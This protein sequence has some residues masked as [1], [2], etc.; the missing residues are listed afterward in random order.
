MF[1]DWISSVRRRA[2]D[3]EG[4]ADFAES[5]RQ[6]IYGLC[7]DRKIFSVAQGRWGTG[8]R[9]AAPVAVRA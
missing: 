5:S 9:A 6:E 8:S 3:H 2:A 7:A 1:V 4:C